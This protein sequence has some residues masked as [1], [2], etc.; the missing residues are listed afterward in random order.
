MFLGCF[1]SLAGHF[2]PIS[3]HFGSY[4]ELLWA[5]LGS[6]LSYSR[7]FELGFFLF[8]ASLDQFRPVL[9]MF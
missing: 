7:P 3:N 5:I 4:F 9:E 2:G 8:R 1:R 6:L